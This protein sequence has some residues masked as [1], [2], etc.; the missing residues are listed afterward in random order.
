MKKREFIYLI[1]IISVI[2]VS[3]FLFLENRKLK[4]ENALLVNNSKDQGNVSTDYNKSNNTDLSK[5]ENIDKNTEDLDHSEIENKNA[6]DK[7]EKGVYIKPLFKIDVYQTGTDY[8]NV[9]AYGPVCTLNAYGVNFSN[10]VKIIGQE[11]DY[12]TR[13]SI[14]GVIPTWAIERDDNYNINNDYNIEYVN[15]KIMYILNDECN[16][17]LTPEDNSKIV[18]T[19]QRGKA[20]TVSA[21]YEDWYFITMNY[22]MDPNLLHY[23][24]VKKSCLG[25]YEDFDSNIGLDVNIK[26]GSPVIY[27]GEDE[28]EIINSSTEWGEISEE[29]DNEYVLKMPGLCFLTIEKKY[30]EPF[31]R[32][33]Q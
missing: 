8:S 24:W 30:V 14:E 13:I 1:V 22:N 9:P 7:E 6:E 16:V 17:F 3:L 27:M 21:K 10:A 31:S 33:E 29:T 28:F 4:A 23:G 32:R 25:Y 26:K 11:D 5:P 15:N 12:L 19:T 20:V 2:C 18:F